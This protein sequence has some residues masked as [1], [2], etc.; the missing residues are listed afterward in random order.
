MVAREKGIERQ[1]PQGFLDDILGRVHVDLSFLES[2]MEILSLYFQ[3]GDEQT[4]KGLSYLLVHTVSS[5]QRY[6]LTDAI[7]NGRRTN[8]IKLLH[9][10]LEQGVPPLLILYI[11]SQEIRLLWGLKCEIERGAP[12][13]KIFDDFRIPDFKRDIYARK[14]QGMPW[15]ELRAVISQLAATDRML[16]S[17][18]LTAEWHLE[19]V[20]DNIMSGLFV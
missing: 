9:E 4:P 7:V 6:L 18:R 2:E 10:F 5:D 11:L 16:K 15:S 8:A 19:R 20:V 13:D 1:L 17:S 14:A 12:V 3:D